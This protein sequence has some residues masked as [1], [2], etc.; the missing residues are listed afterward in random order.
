ME[1]KAFATRVRLRLHCAHEV[2]YT[3]PVVNAGL[4]DATALRRVAFLVI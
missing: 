2:F 3:G 4:D 1:W